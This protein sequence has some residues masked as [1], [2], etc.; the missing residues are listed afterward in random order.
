MSKVKF[1][2]NYKG[3]G[4]LLRSDGMQS[5]LQEYAKGVQGRAGSGYEISMHVGKS[6]ANVSVYAAT[7]AAVRD[8]YKNNTLLKALGG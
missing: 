4:E 7:G 6:R 3:V 1:E 8:T 2:L 5:V